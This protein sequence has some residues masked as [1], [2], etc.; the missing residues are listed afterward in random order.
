LTTKVDI[1]NNAYSQLRI[2]GLTVNP[3]N[4]D[5]EVALDR[6][7]SMAAEFEDRNICVNYAFEDTPDLNTP[8]NIERKFWYSLESLLALR[9][10]PDFGKGQQPDPLLISAA[11]TGYSFLSANTA[12]L[13]EI[14]H[15]ARQPVGSKNRWARPTFGK[16]YQP[17]AEAPISCKTITMYIDDVED[18]VEHYDAWLNDGEVISS[19][20]IEADTGLTVSGDTISD[21]E[22]DIEYT[23]TATGID[24]STDSPLLRIKI[25]V[26]SDASRIL[27]RIINFELKS[28]E[29]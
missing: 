21:S 3:T 29:L 6:L 18:F 22:T 26:T 5:L 16:F 10:M 25:V 15:P 17:V 13:R 20:T 28:S 11:Q 9:L 1:I 2:S 4:E 27:T 24:D 23:V 19:Y 14:Q 7:E 12:K 8:H